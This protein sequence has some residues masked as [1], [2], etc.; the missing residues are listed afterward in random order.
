MRIFRFANGLTPPGNRGNTGAMGPAGAKFA[1]A[2]P[3][4][5]G[6][7]SGR[8][9]AP[10]SLAMAWNPADRNTTTATVTLSNGNLTWTLSNPAS[11]GTQ[12]GI[13]GFDCGIVGG[14]AHKL[15]FSAKL[16][17]LDNQPF[18]GIGVAD[19]APNPLVPSSLL[20]GVT[21]ENGYEFYNGTNNG[22]TSFA[23]GAGDVVDTAV[24]TGLLLIWWRKNG[25][26]WA[27]SGDPAA[28]TGG[29]PI[30]NLSGAGIAPYSN[31][32]GNGAP[33][34]QWTANFGETAYPF[35]APS[36]FL[37]WTR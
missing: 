13:R 14:A 24:D 4:L 37:N 18:T 11:G 27:P 8:G 22:G 20:V 26:S 31:L 15:F 16:D 32:G 23:Y 12:N 10:P 1:Q 34:G 3:A 30:T 25:G 21:C 36:G 33:A 5:A 17:A 9:G 6:P 19:L 7:A 35:A 2:A 28:G 29:R